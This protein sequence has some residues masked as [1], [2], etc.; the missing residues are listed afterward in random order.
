MEVDIDKEM[1]LRE[2]EMMEFQVAGNEMD[3]LDWI[4]G[5]SIEKE[6]PRIPRRTKPW[7]IWR[8]EQLSTISNLELNLD[9]LLSLI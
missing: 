4:H 3:E 5:E 7:M 9:G 6:G 1:T 8:D 2:L